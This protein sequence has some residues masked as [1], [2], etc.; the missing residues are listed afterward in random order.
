V[1]FTVERK[2]DL[3][4]VLLKPSLSFFSHNLKNLVSGVVIKTKIGRFGKKKNFD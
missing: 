4:S 2:E 3:H 1:H